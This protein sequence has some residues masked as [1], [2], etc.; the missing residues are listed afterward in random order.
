MSEREPDFI[1]CE[2]MNCT[3]RWTEGPPYVGS[4]RCPSE[5]CGSKNVHVVEVFDEVVGSGLTINRRD[6]PSSQDVAGQV[7]DRLVVL[8]ERHWNADL[9]L[10]DDD[11][12]AFVREQVIDD[13]VA[14][15]ERIDLPMTTKKP[16]RDL[17]VAGGI[18]QDR[19]EVPM[20]TMIAQPAASEDYF[21]GELQQHRKHRQIDAMRRYLSWAALQPS[22]RITFARDDDELVVLH[23]VESRQ[24]MLAMVHE[25]TEGPHCWRSEPGWMGWEYVM[26]KDIHGVTYVLYG[27]EQTVEAG[28]VAA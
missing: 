20:S 3:E 21:L 24:Q 15:V 27:G 7:A 10:W 19:Q 28:P 16:P 23:P 26:S 22:A 4:L 18:D 8:V 12:R 17:H 5:D 11:H 2:C 25:F 1:D 14:L 9:P 6:C 13:L